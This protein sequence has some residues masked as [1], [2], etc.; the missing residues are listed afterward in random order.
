MK[1]IK[2]LPSTTSIFEDSFFN[3]ARMENE[4]RDEYKARLKENKRFMKMYKRFGRDRFIQFMDFMKKMGEQE[5]A[6]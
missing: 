5:N 3:S 1:N 4:T 6:K 2:Q